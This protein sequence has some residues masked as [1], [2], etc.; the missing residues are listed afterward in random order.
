[1]QD[2]VYQ[3]PIA[4]VLDRLDAGDAIEDALS[5]EVKFSSSFD[6][7]DLLFLLFRL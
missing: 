5:L 3:K 6:G 2:R 4:R 7:V 1:M